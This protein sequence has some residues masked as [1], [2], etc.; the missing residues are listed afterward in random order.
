MAAGPSPT[1]P[2]VTRVKSIPTPTSARQSTVRGYKWGDD[3]RDFADLDWSDETVEDDERDLPWSAVLK[4]TFE[5][6]LRG[7]RPNMYGE[8]INWSTDDDRDY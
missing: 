6:Y 1:K 8:Y 5:A 7:E 3:E 4:R 2:G